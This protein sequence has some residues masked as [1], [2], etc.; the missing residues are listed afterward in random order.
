MRTVS[1]WW[2]RWTSTQVVEEGENE[3]DPE[4]VQ[5]VLAHPLLT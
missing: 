2:R 4:A 5:A 3:N 1:Y